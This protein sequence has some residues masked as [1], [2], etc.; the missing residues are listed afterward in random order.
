M[1]AEFFKT[2]LFNSIFIQN[3]LEKQSA[4]GSPGVSRGDTHSP[5]GG[6]QGLGVCGAGASWWEGG[7]E[8][9]QLGGQTTSQAGRLGTEK[10]GGNKPSSFHWSSR[11]GSAIIPG[12][13]R[14]LHST[15]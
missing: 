6:G 10:P 4:V 15:I 13:G 1:I 5:G 8:L 14:N 2:F 7:Q 9:R 3:L 11:A 12:T